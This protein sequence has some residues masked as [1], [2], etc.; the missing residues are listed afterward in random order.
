MWQRS[1]GRGETGLP[2]GRVL[3]FRKYLANE[4]LLACLTAQKL[5]RE[6]VINREQAVAGLK[7]VRLRQIGFEE[8]ERS[9]QI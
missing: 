8:S 9:Q 3:V 7:A 5:V 1:E 6:G 2:V 4:V